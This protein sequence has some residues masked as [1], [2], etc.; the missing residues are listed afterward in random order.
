MTEDI[1]FCYNAKEAP[2]REQN[3]AIKINERRKRE[4]KSIARSFL[5]RG[6]QS[7]ASSLIL[8]VQKYFIGKGN[9]IIQQPSSPIYSFMVTSSLLSFPLSLRATYLTEVEL[10]SLVYANKKVTNM[11]EW[12]HGK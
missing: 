12:T 11:G 4:A 6:I 8:Y 7:K 1:F 9:K 3:T 10:F 5:L 2:G